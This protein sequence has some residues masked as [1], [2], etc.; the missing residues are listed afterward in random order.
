MPEAARRAGFTT[1]NTVQRALRN[2]GVALV[3]INSRALAVEEADLNRFM[4]ERSRAGYSG[5]GRP[6]KTKPSQ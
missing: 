6:T 3:Q 5:R 2:A 1:T 4:E